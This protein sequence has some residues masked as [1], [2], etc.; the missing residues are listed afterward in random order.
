MRNSANQYGAQGQGI[1]LTG[2]NSSIQT[3]G[4]NVGDVGGNVAITT[5][6]GVSENALENIFGSLSR[7]TSA[8]VAAATPPAVTTPAASTGTDADATRKKWIRYGLMALAALAVLFLA[9]KF[10]KK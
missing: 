3:G 1:V 7:A 9:K 10:F 8:Q 6:T 2:N 5:T 4:N